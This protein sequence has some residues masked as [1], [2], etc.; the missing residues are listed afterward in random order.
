MTED[1][2]AEITAFVDAELASAE[3][4]F[5]EGRYSE[6]WSAVEEVRNEVRRRGWWLPQMSQKEGGMGLELV[7][8]ARVAEVL[9]RNPVAHLAFNCQAPDAGNMELLALHGT[10][11]Q[12]AEFLEPLL[13]GK[14][15]SC[16]SMTEPGRPGSNPTWMETEAVR[17]SDEWVINGRKWFTTAADGADFAVVMAVTDPDEPKH[18]QASMF[19][20]PTDTP[21]FEL[22]RNI[23]VMGDAGSGHASHAEIEYR[24]CRVPAKNLLGERGTGFQMAQ[25]RLGPGR[26]HHCMR[27]LG[28]CERAIDL[29]SR[30]ALERKI[31]PT[32]RLADEGVTQERIAESRIEVDAARAYVMK[33]A[34][35]IDA[36]GVRA[37]R[38]A[39]SGIKVFVAGVLQRVLDRAVQIYGA[40]GMT[41]ATPLAYWYAHERGARIYDGP[42]EVHRRLIARMELERVKKGE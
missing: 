4:H 10:S 18:R 21:G 2:L 32:R 24:E 7:D 17:D 3:R 16:F 34:R 11:T 13:A 26:I 1:L 37:H 31:T 38:A 36:D 33:T 20:V 19:L 12:R 15:R 23:S 29:M 28:I 30:R 35:A 14:K 9:G 5:L 25:E 40:R 39:V 41:D 6:T 42:D 22:V 27:W 8:F